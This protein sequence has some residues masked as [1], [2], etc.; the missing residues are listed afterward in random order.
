M[1]QDNAKY[2]IDVRG[3]SFFYEKSDRQSQILHNVSLK[4]QEGSF[5]V[6][7]GPS[8]SGKTTLLSILGCLRQ[9]EVG[10]ILV[11]GAELVGMSLSELTQLRRKL[12]FIFQDHN[13][14]NSLTAKQNVQMALGLN[15]D[16]S[17]SASEAAATHILKV[18]DLENRADC[19]PHQLSG[20]QRQR[21]AAARALVNNPKI[22]FADEPTAALDTVARDQFIRLVKKLGLKRR[23]ST[24]MIT[25]D[26]RI[27]EQADQVFW[28]QDGSLL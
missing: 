14:H 1:I 3:L 20:G 19:L 6:L 11:M 18:F 22:I 25:H 12:G 21:V 23:T 16:I 13:L 28:L 17:S 5:N 7:A 10:S 2:I 27:I 15:L 8:G 4:I 26:A 24:L 9:A